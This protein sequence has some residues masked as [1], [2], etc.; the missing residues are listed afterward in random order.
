MMTSAMVVALGMVRSGQMMDI[1]KT[2]TNRQNNGRNLRK[3]SRDDGT[4]F[5]C[6][7][8]NR[9]VDKSLHS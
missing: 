7:F 4:K 3:K 5:L 2:E 8:L 9:K 1:L 6:G